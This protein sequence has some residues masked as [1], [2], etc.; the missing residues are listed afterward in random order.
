LVPDVTADF[1]CRLRATRQGVH[2]SGRVYG[3]GLYDR[4]AFPLYSWFGAKG[5][6]HCQLGIEKCPWP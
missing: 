3:A 1:D 4:M 2:W 5:L 6:L